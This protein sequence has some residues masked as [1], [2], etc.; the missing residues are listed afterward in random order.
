M[1]D[2]SV[3]EH[4]HEVVSKIMSRCE[5][6]CDDVMRYDTIEEFNVDS[7]DSKAECGR[8]NPAQVE[9]ET[10]QYKKEE[11]KNKQTPVPT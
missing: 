4:C 9:P 5:L 6:R 3:T 1:N 8:R 7:I 10:D 11:T 2:H